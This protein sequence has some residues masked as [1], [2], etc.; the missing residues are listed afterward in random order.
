MCIEIGHALYQ[1][2]PVYAASS[3]LLC[4][5][6]LMFIPGIFLGNQG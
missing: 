3:N 5:K 4:C 6:S 1:K 2:K